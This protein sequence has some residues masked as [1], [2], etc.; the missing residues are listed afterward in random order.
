MKAPHVGFL[1]LVC[2]FQYRLPAKMW[3]REPWLREDSTTLASGVCDVSH[4]IHAHIHAQMYASFSWFVL[5]QC[6]TGETKTNK[7]DDFKETHVK[8][9]IYPVGSFNTKLQQQQR[10]SNRTNVI[11][12]ILPAIVN[13]ADMHNSKTRVSAWYPKGKR[14]TMLKNLM[15]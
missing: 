6:N 5:V 9:V 13:W 1:S 15:L 11:I 2:H 10:K 12:P 7:N 8:N 14:K 4:Q 3:C